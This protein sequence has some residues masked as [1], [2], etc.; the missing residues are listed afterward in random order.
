M[1]R[2]IGGNAKV[3]KGW[4]FSNA[5]VIAPVL[6][7]QRALR[8]G[9]SPVSSLACFDSGAVTHGVSFAPFGAWSTFLT[10]PTAC[11]GLHSFAASRLS[12]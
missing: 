4:D 9:R 3:R 1:V 12:R 11:A 2:D 8:R 7:E 10:R 6:E 5:D